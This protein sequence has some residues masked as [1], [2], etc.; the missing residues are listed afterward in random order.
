MRAAILVALLHVLAPYLSH[1]TR[2]RYADVITR[3]ARREHVD[4]LLVT[5]IIEHESRWQASADNGR[6]VGLGQVC[7]ST[8]RAC[9]GA[10]GLDAPTCRA[11]RQELLDGAT[12]IHVMVGQLAAA[13]QYCGV[14]ADVRAVVSSYAGTGV[15]G[16]RGGLRH[17]I[18]NAILKIRRELKKRGT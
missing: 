2:Q 18:V 16:A 15:C 8:Q 1:G 3:E 4:P 10:D 11:R 5:A 17:S 7:L 9:R 14:H 13:R 6:C 12:N